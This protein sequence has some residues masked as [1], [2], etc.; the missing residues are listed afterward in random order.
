MPAVLFVCSANRV[1]SPMAAA[2]F[3][4]LL[5][6]AGQT[7]WLVDSAGTWAL[8][9]GAPAASGA[10]DTLARRGLDLS[11]HRTKDVSTLALEIY[12]LI[13]V[14]EPGQKEALRIE[15]PCAAR[16]VYLLSELS[17][18]PRPVADPYG[19]NPEAFEACAQDLERLLQRGIERIVGLCVP[20]SD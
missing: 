19:Q 9:G 7:G 14:M 11:R 8:P 2:L 13:L 20:E 15:F 16:R 1:R 3:A 17:G 12:D 5:E 10:V 6:E 4:R 18:P